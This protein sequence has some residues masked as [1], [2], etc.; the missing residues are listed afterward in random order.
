MNDRYKPQRTSTS[1]YRIRAPFR[2]SGSTLQKSWTS[3]STRVTGIVEDGLFCPWDAQ[4]PAHLV[5]DHAG[6]ITQMT[7]GFA[8]EHDAG[9]IH[10]PSLAHTPSLR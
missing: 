5:D 7:T 10:A 9:I 6:V 1:D 2:R 4:V 3:P 8:D